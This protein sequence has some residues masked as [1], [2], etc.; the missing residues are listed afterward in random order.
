M[1][2]YYG[3]GYLYTFGSNET[4]ADT[5]ISTHELTISGERQRT[6]NGTLTLSIDGN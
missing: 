3:S 2:A 4:N 1:S 5:L 6:Q